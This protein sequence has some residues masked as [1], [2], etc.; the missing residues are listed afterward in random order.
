MK[1]II[2][3]AALVI[4][5][6]QNSCTKKSNVCVTC[7]YVDIHYGEKTDY[8]NACGDT[9]LDAT[10]KATKQVEAATQ[11]VQKYDAVLQCTTEK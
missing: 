9:E 5:F 11:Q 3:F 1:N 8:Q 10:I 4:F 6:L 2:L 7:Y